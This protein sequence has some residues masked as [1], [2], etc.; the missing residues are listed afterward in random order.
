MAPSDVE[1]LCLLI[2]RPTLTLEEAARIIAAR[3]RRPRPLTL[4]TENPNRPQSR[5]TPDR[6]PGSPGSPNSWST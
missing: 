4:T 5:E 2:A 3:R 1:L 6:R